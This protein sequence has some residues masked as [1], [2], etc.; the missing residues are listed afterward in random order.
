M[1]AIMSE[2]AQTGPSVLGRRSYAFVLALTTVLGLVASMAGAGIMETIAGKDSLQTIE[3]GIVSAAVVFVFGYIARSIRH[4][5]VRVWTYLVVAAAI[6]AILED[7]TALASALTPV[8]SSALSVFTV[9]A[10]SALLM[11]VATVI[12]PTIL[13]NTH[14]RALVVGFL[15]VFVTIPLAM[16]TLGVHIMNPVDFILMVAAIVWITFFNW[17]LRLEGYKGSAM[18]TMDQAIDDALSIYLLRQKLPAESAAR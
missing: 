16:F 4:P 5:H 17:S 8:H 9:A 18:D 13:G 6:G 11:G 2:V 1:S 10:L 12:R 3:V 14:Q 15:Q 7:I